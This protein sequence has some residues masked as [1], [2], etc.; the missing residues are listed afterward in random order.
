MADLLAVLGRRERGPSDEYFTRREDVEAELVHYR[1]H[2]AGKTVLC[3]CDTRESEFWRWFERNFEELGLR[4]LQGVCWRNKNPDRRGIGADPHGTWF[5]IG[6]EEAV[7]YGDG[8]FRGEE[9][10]RIIGAADVVVT[11]PPFSQ[12]LSFLTQMAESGRQFL[13]LGAPSAAAADEVVPLIVAGKLW[14]GVNEVRRFDWAGGTAKVWAFWFTNMQPDRRRGKLPLECRYAPER[15]PRYDNAPSAVDVSAL[16]LIPVDYRGWMG[17]PV[18]IFAQH[19][20]DQFEMGGVLS[21]PVLRGKKLFKRLIIRHRRVEGEGGSRAGGRT[22][23]P[24]SVRAA[25]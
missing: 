9:V 22:S 3:C 24:Q 19:N 23:P 25:D 7:L 10:R 2:F 17:V 5:R 1:R 13:C 6:G 4:D 20:P 18:T 21:A 14:A 15:Y 8:D 16:A 11:N 12:I